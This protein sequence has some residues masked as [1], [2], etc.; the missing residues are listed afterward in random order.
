MD[1]SAK[2]WEHR[3]VTNDIGWDLGQVSP[4]LKKYFDQLS[5]KELKILIPGGGN[6]Y[7]VEYL[8]NRGFTN[9]F[10][11][12]L[13]KTAID[14]IKKRV[15]SF[16]K[17][18]LILGNFFDLIGSFDLIIEQTF[19]CAIHP[20]LRSQYVVKMN[21]LLLPKG[22]LVGLLFNVPL[23]KDRPPFGGNKKEY[24]KWFQ[25]YFSIQKMEACYNSFGNRQGRE[26]FIH[27]IKKEAPQVLLP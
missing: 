15:P 13:S 7:E 6:S 4:A 24:M 11:I 2:A 14:N 17:S 25:S 12:D 10:V 16:P 26:L 27:L 18:Q 22:K 1:L 8:F 23:H 3:Y 5:N 9:V 21:Q 20:S 19:F